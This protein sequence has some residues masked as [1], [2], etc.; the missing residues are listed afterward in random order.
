M[1]FVATNFYPSNT[2]LSLYIYVYSE[3]VEFISWYGLLL[4]TP[5]VELFRNYMTNSSSNPKPKSLS[6]SESLLLI[7]KWWYISIFLFWLQKAGNCIG[8]QSSSFLY[9][10]IVFW[11]SSFLDMCTIPFILEVILSFVISTFFLSS[12]S[13]LE[14]CLWLK[15]KYSCKNNDQPF[16]EKI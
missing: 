14:E 8:V 5:S 2:V 10:R 15:C 16:K 4:K 11:R 9:S 3:Q 7:M 6:S 13:K 12:C 1:F